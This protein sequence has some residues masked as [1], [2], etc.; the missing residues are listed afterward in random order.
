ME[1]QQALR[2]VSEH[3]QEVTRPGAGS[4][5][6][7]A[8]CDLAAWWFTQA[9]LLDL[10]AFGFSMAG[11]E[12]GRLQALDPPT[13]QDSSPGLIDAAT[14]PGHVALAAGVRRIISARGHTG[15]HAVM[16]RNV[17]AMGIMGSAVRELA[18]AGF[19]GFTV[20]NSAP[21]VA[22]WGGHGP[23]A[24]TNPIAAAA[25]TDGAPV[26]VDF[27]TSA[28]TFAQLRGARLSG[29]DLP[30]PGGL[31]AGGH[32]TRD[33]ANVKAL[34]PASLEGSLGGFVVELLTGVVLGRDW[35]AGRSGLLLALDPE[36]FGTDPTV[37][38]ADFAR[39]WAHAGGHVPSRF[40]ALPATAEEA[41]ETLNYDLETLTELLRS[42]S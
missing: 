5:I 14:I 20:A 15:V 34:I 3:L 4:D 23:A 7:S 18:L 10:P 33:A 13:P 40:A 9:E 6:G 39:T 36:F 25:P 30:E 22:P 16:L 27:A 35:D 37:T 2:V 19:V 42:S 24:G 21:M 17:G 41:P 31:D 1:T 12:I 29:A 28:L 11:R 26:V 8:D 38:G 32:P